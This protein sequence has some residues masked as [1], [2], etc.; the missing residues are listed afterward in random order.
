[1][2]RGY[3]PRRRPYAGARPAS[4]LG[5]DPDRPVQAL[6]ARK[7]RCRREDEREEETAG[8][9]RSPTKGGAGVR[10]ANIAQG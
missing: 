5:R 4:R 6:R 8:S 7:R 10:L 3:D 1:M 2:P 9:R